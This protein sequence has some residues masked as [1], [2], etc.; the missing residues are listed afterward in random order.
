MVKTVDL[1]LSDENM[2]EERANNLAG[3]RTEYHTRHYSGNS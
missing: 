2:E 1:E 3:T